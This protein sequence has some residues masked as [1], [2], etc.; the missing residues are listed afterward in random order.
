MVANSGINYS[1]GEGGSVMLDGS[2]SFDPDGTIVSYEWDFDYDGVDFNADVLGMTSSFSALGLDGPTIRTVAL[3]VTDEMGLTHISTADVFITNRFPAVNLG[4]DRSGVEGSEVTINPSVSDAGDDML[5]YAW[6][7]SASNGQVIA[8]SSDSSFS[9]TPVDQGVYTVLLIVTDDD[10]GQM[11][12]TMVVTV[13]N[14]GPMVGIGGNMTVGEGTP[15]TIG[16]SFSDPGADTLSHVWSVVASNGQVI[17][18]HSGSMMSFTPVDNGVYTV[19]L[20]VSDEDGGTTSQST[21]VTVTNVAPT[22]NVGSDMTVLEGSLVSFTGTYSDVGADTHSLVWS[23]LASNGQVISNGSGS[24]F[25]FTV[26]DNG[27]YTVTFKVTDDDGGTGMDSLTVHVNNANPNAA[28]HGPNKTVRGQAQNYSGTFSDAGP[29]DTHQVRWD[30]GDGDVIAWHSTNDAGAMNVNKSWKK[31]GNYSVTMSIRDK[32]GAVSTSTQLV[33][34]A[35]TDH[36]GGKKNEVVTTEVLTVGG[37]LDTMMLF[38]QPAMR[39]TSGG[40]GVLVGVDGEM[41]GMFNALKKIIAYDDDGMTRRE[42]TMGQGNAGKVL[43]NVADRLLDRAAA[44]FFRR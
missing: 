17:D 8:N 23:V 33:E 15:V 13:S 38:F 41:Q 32:D 9:F 27:I 44:R 2:L 21:V 6:S 26:L 1:V 39:T 10:G 5:T 25:S 42:I 43:S 34:V 16:G 24:S 19:T 3:R 11:S 30:F 36:G 4:E 35:N 29:V 20:T 7:V 18:S 14:V 28:L 22:V 12:D 40:M 37:D 31:K